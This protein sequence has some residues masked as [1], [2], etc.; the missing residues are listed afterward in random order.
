[1]THGQTQIKDVKTVSFGMIPIN[2][3][4]EGGPCGKY[5][6]ALWCC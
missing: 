2:G 6:K 3:G 5:S 1:M 4:F